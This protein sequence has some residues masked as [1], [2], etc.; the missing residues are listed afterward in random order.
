MLRKLKKSRAARAVA[1]ARS[2][3]HPNQCDDRAAVEYEMRKR[4]LAK[5]SANKKAIRNI[6]KGNIAAGRH[7]LERD[8]AE[9]IV[10]EIFGWSDPTE[11]WIRAVGWLVGQGY[12]ASRHHYK[13]PPDSTDPL[14]FV[15]S[16]MPEINLSS[17]VLKV[18]ADAEGDLKD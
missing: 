3:I 14:D 8:E 17:E 9:Q 11:S 7:P 1:L 2:E 5:I 16:E 18:I 4:A 12:A 15:D 10:S 6:K 13:T